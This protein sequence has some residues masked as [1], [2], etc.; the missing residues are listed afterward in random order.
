MMFGEGISK[1]G[2]IVDLGAK[3]PTYYK[4]VHGFL[5]KALQN[6]VK[7]EE[8][9][10]T[11]FIDNPRVWRLEVEEHQEKHLSSQ[12]CPSWSRGRANESDAEFIAAGGGYKTE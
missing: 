10:K 1:T 2:E 8:A 3:K 5:M 7:V 12:P 11:I 4:M 6:C 9:C